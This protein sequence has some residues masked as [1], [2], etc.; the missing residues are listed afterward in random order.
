MAYS[1]TSSQPA[2]R[3]DEFAEMLSQG[4]EVPEISRRMGVTKAS[5]RSLLVKLRRRLGPQAV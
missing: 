1:A 5:G 2:P 4:L 3:L